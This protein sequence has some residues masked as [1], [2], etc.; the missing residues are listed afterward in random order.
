MLQSRDFFPAEN[1]VL[2][3]AM[4]YLH[5]PGYGS[6]KQRFRSTAEVSNILDR[7]LN[8]V[9]IL[10]ARDML[11]LSEEEHSKGKACGTFSVPGLSVWQMS[12]DLSDG[13]AEPQLRNFSGTKSSA[14][15]KTHK[16]SQN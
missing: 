2:G 9:L 12:S 6:N 14:Q 16:N 10:S 13:Q 5:H 4:P 15:W 8:A 3:G 1:L 11:F 7:S